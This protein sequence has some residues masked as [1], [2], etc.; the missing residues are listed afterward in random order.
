MY[1]NGKFLW[2]LA[3]HPVPLKFQLDMLVKLL[4]VGTNSLDP[5]VLTLHWSAGLKIS[6]SEW[7]GQ[8]HLCNPPEGLSQR[9]K[10]GMSLKGSVT[11]RVLE[12]PSLALWH[13]QQYFPNPNFYHILCSA[14]IS[15]WSKDVKLREAQRLVHLKTEPLIQLPENSSPSSSWQRQSQ[16][17]PCV[18]FPFSLS[19]H[20]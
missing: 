9:S 12:M 6:S 2:L 18:L 11:E 13:S 17:Q 16:Y 4:N 8:K 20:Y 19:S 5:H 15:L 7:D 1:R 14:F 3:Y 10:D